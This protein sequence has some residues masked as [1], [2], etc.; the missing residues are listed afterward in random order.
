MTS[1]EMKILYY[2]INREEAKISAF[3][4]AKIDKNECLTGEETLPSNRRQIIEQAKFIYPPL[5]KALVKSLNLS[6]KTDELKNTDGIFPK[7]MSNNLIINNLKGIIELQDI[8]K[9]D[10]LYYKSKCRNIYNFGKYSLPI[11]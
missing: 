7:N 1:L 9:T 11:V 4:S 6:N 2:E 8:T 3:S 10:E 5:G